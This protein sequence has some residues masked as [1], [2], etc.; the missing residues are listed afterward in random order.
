[1]YALK[2]SF[3]R[4]TSICFLD[5]TTKYNGFHESL[6]RKEKEFIFS[7]IGCHFRLQN[8]VKTFILRP[9]KY[10]LSVKIHKV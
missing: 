2:R 6:G 1:M 10:R 8:E 7:V 9:P 4:I 5:F 3:R